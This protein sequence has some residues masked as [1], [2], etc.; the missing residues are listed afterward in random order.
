MAQRR[1]TRI[2]PMLHP[3][4]QASLARLIQKQVIPRLRLSLG[5]HQQARCERV[6]EFA[7]VLMH[8]DRRAAE[9]FV[10][11]RRREGL[12]PAQVHLEILAPVARHLCAQW[13]RR[14][15][16]FPQVSAALIR[17][18]AVLRAQKCQLD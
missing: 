16:S 9:T 3:E 1:S 2:A 11:L 7:L 12:T 18:L 17:L 4:Q 10:S 6:A 14:E 8:G 5:D 15:C 13:E